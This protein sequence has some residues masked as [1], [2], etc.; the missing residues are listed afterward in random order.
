M[1]HTSLPSVALSHPLLPLLSLKTGIIAVGATH[2]QIDTPLAETI[3]AL[4][5]HG[6]R[7]AVLVADSHFDGHPVAQR[8]HDRGHVKLSFAETPYQVRFLLHR[9]HFACA[10]FSIVVVVGLLE[11][12]YDEQIKEPQAELLLDDALRL[13]DRLAATLRVMVILTPSTHQT[14]P[15]LVKTVRERVASYLELAALEA[16]N[17]SLQGRLF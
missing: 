4:A 8:L 11:T 1:E 5:N 16:P 10:E 7:I 2:A 14:R 17:E 9:L 13:L 3:V 6:E 12:F 15:Q